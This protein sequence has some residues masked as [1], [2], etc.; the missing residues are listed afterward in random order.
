MGAI[1]QHGDASG[2][3]AH[4]ND[5]A[6]PVSQLW[7]PSDS[8]FTHLETGADKKSVGFLVNHYAYSISRKKSSSI[9]QNV[10]AQGSD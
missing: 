7:A 1:E 6:S 3:R 5:N 2:T 8:K 9:K 4:L 10:K